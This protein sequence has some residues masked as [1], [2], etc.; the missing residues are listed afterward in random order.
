MLWGVREDGIPVAMY[1]F[2]NEENA[3]MDKSAILESNFVSYYYE[4]CSRQDIINTGLIS[5]AVTVKNVPED[6]TEDSDLFVIKAYEH[7]VVNEKALMTNAQQSAI[8]NNYNLDVRTAIDGF[9]IVVFYRLDE[10]SD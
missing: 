1:T 6:L 8:D 4:A 3:S 5:K 2:W 9:P 10:N 7:G